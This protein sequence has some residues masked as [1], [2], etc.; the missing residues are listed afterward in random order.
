MESGSLLL[1]D[2]LLTDVGRWEISEGG[3]YSPMKL[4]VERVSGP[5]ASQETKESIVNS[6]NA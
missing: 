2:F 1:T 5:I 4:T 6:P 3:F